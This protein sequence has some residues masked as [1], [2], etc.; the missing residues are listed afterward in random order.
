MSFKPLWARV[1]PRKSKNQPT[2][3]AKCM[4]AVS[5]L[6]A[7]AS[8]WVPWSRNYHPRRDEHGRSWN[9]KITAPESSP[10]EPQALWLSPWA[11][12]SLSLL[13]VALFCPPQC[14]FTVQAREG[15]T[16]P[17]VHSFLSFPPQSPLTFQISLSC[18]TQWSDS[19]GLSH[20]CHTHSLTVNIPYESVSNS[21]KS[22]GTNVRS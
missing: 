2:K 9:N 4:A 14:G 1:R 7:S 12:R 16:L 20:T 8:F 15:S 17:G 19:W 22:T 6:Q 11:H 5:L 3:Q 10:G 13:S 21:P 18:L